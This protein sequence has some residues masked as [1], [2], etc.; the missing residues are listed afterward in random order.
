MKQETIIEWVKALLLSYAIIL[1]GGYVY[2]LLTKII[3]DLTETYWIFSIA[4][5][6]VGY[7]SFYILDKFTKLDKVPLMIFSIFALFMT[8]VQNEL[9]LSI[10]ISF[11]TYNIFELLPYIGFGEF[12]LLLFW[13]PLRY[14]IISTLD[15]N[16]NN[17]SH[18]AFLVISILS[19]IKV[20]NDTKSAPQ[21]INP[22]M[23]E[24]F[25]TLDTEEQED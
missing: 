1:V 8:I 19:T 9:Y 12:L 17:I 23:F 2:A 10:M 25:N 16:V 11:D 21:M 18:I 22:D 3:I 20:I 24:S 5:I 4:Y 7:L 6:G 15:F 13:D 14:G